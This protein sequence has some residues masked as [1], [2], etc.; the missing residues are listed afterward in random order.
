[1]SNTLVAIRAAFQVTY[2]ASNT[3]I[4]GQVGDQRHKSQK[5]SQDLPTYRSRPRLRTVPSRSPCARDD[6]R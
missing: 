3:T 4:I 5:L 6:D 1:M 2:M